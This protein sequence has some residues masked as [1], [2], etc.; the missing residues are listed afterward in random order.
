MPRQQGAQAPGSGSS[1][2]GRRGWGMICVVVVTITV[3]PYPGPAGPGHTWWRICPAP[4]Q[5]DR[6][7]LR[8]IQS[9]KAPRV[10][11]SPPSDA[12]TGS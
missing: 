2:S 12:H 6:T 8:H 5:G 10:H 3:R 11:A 4:H 9:Q 1:V 7:V